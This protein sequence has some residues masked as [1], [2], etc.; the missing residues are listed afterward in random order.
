MGGDR[1]GH[2][3]IPGVGNTKK[4]RD[5]APNRIPGREEPL[6]SGKNDDLSME[7]NVGFGKA[8]E[9]AVLDRVAKLVGVALQQ[10]YTGCGSILGSRPD[11]V[12]LDQTAQVVNI[13]NLAFGNA[14]DKSAA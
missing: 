13:A 12:Q 4:R 1:G 5:K 11:R 2:I 9:D 6:V 14:D 10:D 3:P 7:S 8:V